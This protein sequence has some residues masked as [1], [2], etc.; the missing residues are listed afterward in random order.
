MKFDSNM[1]IIVL[2]I[3]VMQLIQ[4]KVKTVPILPSVSDGDV[5]VSQKVERC[6]LVVAFEH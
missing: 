3:I 6:P 5:W 2:D 1:V 4:I